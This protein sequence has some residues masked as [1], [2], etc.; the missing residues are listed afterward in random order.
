MSQAMFGL[1]YTVKKSLKNG[2]MPSQGI[3]RLR[4]LLSEGE[5]HSNE[6]TASTERLKGAGAHDADKQ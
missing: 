2:K 5:E 1:K 4:A 6:N 3:F